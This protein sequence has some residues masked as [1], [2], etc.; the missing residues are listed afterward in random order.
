VQN[1]LHTGQINVKKRVDKSRR[2][3]MTELYLQWLEELEFAVTGIEVR[4]VFLPAHV[5][6]LTIF[7]FRT[8]SM[9]RYQARADAYQVSVAPH[10]PSSTGLLIASYL[11]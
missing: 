9:L 7:L 2:I 3:I 10:S 5:A 4:R 11:M 1:L 8:C 6:I